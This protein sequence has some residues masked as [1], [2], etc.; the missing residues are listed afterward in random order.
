MANYTCVIKS[1]IFEVKD[2]ESFIEDIEEIFR[3]ETLEKEEGIQIYYN[4]LNSPRFTINRGFSEQEDEFL[5]ELNRDHLEIQ[6]YISQNLNEGEICLIKEVGNTKLRRLSAYAVAVDSDGE[7]VSLHLR[8]I[9]TL[10]Q[11]ELKGEL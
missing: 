5:D 9:E 2:R 7:T 8:D 11:K 1:N 4:D 3:F 6:E 10:A